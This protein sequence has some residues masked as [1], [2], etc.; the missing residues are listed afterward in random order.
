MKL[1]IIQAVAVLP[2][3]D[4]F[5]VIQ[6]ALYRLL[7]VAL[8]ILAVGLVIK[9]GANQANGPKGKPKIKSKKK[10]TG[11]IFG[12]YGLGLACSPE[13]EEGHTVVLGGTGLGK[14]S[15]LL[16]PTLRSW[17]GT[18]F[19][20]DISGDINSNVEMP[21]KLIFEP[22]N[23]Q[24]TPYNIFALVDGARGI[25]D[26]NERLAELS[27]LI[28]PPGIREHDTTK[29]FRDGGRKI[30]TGSLL[31]FYH[32]GLDFPEICEKIIESDYLT[33][34]GEIKD[35][36]GTAAYRYIASFQ[37]TSPQN[38]AGCKQ[39]LDDAITLFATNE[40]LKKALRRPHS[41][42]T[43]I[44]AEEL[45][46]SSVFVV[47]EESKLEVLAPLLHILTAQTLSYLT[48]RPNNANPTILL[49]LDEFPALGKLSI[50]NALRTLR[51]KNVR[52]MVLLQS[53]ADLDLI[54]GK[55]E[56]QS[57][58]NNFAFTAI[59]GCSDPDTQELMSRKIGEKNVTKKSISRNDSTTTQT[60]TEYKERIIQPAELDRLGNWLILLSPGGYLKLRK[61][62]YFE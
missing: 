26:K 3:K 12:K 58:I 48:T 5:D 49:C 31:C 54:Y 42:E 13:V 4:I 33:L 55:D 43:G 45:E 28:M 9:Y 20:I 60:E 38:T 8:V 7:V 50:L 25:E 11:I 39:S 35:K 29:F 23:P 16:I 47:L 46:R 1:I 34:L 24:T 18:A 21:N 44:S 62:F 37:G 10:A 30:L 2:Q 61:N 17:N 56:R 59:L 36:G 14:T 53:M 51:K 15:A 41:S 6:S 22:G 19:V 57:M 32:M 40:K 27:Y 52:M